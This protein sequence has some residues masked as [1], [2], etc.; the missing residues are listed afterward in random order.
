MKVKLGASTVEYDTEITIAERDAAGRT[1]R[2]QVTGRE[3]R[4]GGRMRAEVTST[5]EPAG[6]GTTVTLDTELDL[7]GKVAQMGRGMIADVSSKLI[8]DFVHS[9]EANV[10]RSPSATATP[11]EGA[12]GA[13]VDLTGAA[14]QAA[15]KRAAPVVIL[16]LLVLWWW[17]R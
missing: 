2:M 7:A 5:L 13:P 4:G 11:P 12:P 8:G 17:R 16:A 15:L 14:G 3:L 6:A 10:L 1:V 9:L